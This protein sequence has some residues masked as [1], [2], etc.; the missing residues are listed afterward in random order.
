ML[1]QTGLTIKE[2]LEQINKFEQNLQSTILYLRDKKNILEQKLKQI[3]K[4]CKHIPV[5]DGTG[6]HG[7]NKGD[8]YYHCSKC[9]YE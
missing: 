7:S 2:E 9:Y 6:R 5:Y 4:S 3:Q 1:N 8:D